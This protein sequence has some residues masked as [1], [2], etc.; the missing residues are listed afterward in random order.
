MFDTFFDA[1]VCLGMSP[2]FARVL[3]WLA[4]VVSCI[5]ATIWTWVDVRRC[6]EVEDNGKT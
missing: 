3:I 4:P 2:C 6:K 1:F 5:Y